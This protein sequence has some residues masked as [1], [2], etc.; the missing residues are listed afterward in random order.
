[1]LPYLSKKYLNVRKKIL[2]PFIIKINPNIVT[3]VA[4]LVALAAGLSFY[5]DLVLLAGFLVLLNGFLDVLDG[6]IAK[7]FG[8]ATKLGDFLDHTLDRVADIFIFLGITFHPSVPLW[9]GFSTIIVVLMVSYLGTQAHALCKKRI[10]GGLLG[11]ADRILFLFIFSIAY[12]FYAKSLY[13][14]IWLIFIL[15][16]VTVIQRFWYSY[17]I[18]KRK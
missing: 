17:K 16:L 3:I 11:R 8:K 1:M 13:Y 9:L 2:K 10:Y 7:Q 5:Y 4:L 12:V 15:S 18:L 14:G 6:E